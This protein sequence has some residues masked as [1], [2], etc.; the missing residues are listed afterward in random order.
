MN[1]K[2]LFILVATLFATSFTSCSNDLIEETAAIDTEIQTKAGEEGAYNSF[3][4]HA[5]VDYVSYPLVYM[6][7]F[8]YYKAEVRFN[9]YEVPD[10]VNPEIH[11]YYA[12]RAEMEIGKKNDNH[13]EFGLTCVTGYVINNSITYEIRNIPDRGYLVIHT[14]AH[15]KNGH[16]YDRYIEVPLSNY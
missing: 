6:D 14:V 7:G 15:H 2:S 13:R 4:P 16:P 8:D 11:G 1:T 9:D 10:S 12:T 5:P 3:F